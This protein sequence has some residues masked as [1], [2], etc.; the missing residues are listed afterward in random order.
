MEPPCLKDCPP[1]K[2]G[3]PTEATR[4]AI[5][6]GFVRWA[7]WPWVGRGIS[8]LGEGLLYSSI[9]STMDSCA[10]WGVLED[11]CQAEFSQK[12]LEAMLLIGVILLWLFCKRM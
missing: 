3:L 5:T 8:L 11:K 1:W 12:I 10:A 2:E 6:W 4:A 7:A 9:R